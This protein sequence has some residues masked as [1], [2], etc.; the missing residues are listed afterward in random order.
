MVSVQ[1]K[2]I[3]Q[4]VV[5]LSCCHVALFFTSLFCRTIKSFLMEDELLNL[6][7]KKVGYLH[8]GQ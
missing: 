5:A 7:K 2:A 8:L 6:P 4:I 3:M 1:T